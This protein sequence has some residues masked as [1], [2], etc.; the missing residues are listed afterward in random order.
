MR[1]KLVRDLV[2]LATFVAM[3][4]VAPAAFASTSSLASAVDAS[5]D[6]MS[7]A[8]SFASPA[9]PLASEAPAPSRDAA[10]ASQS[11][12]SPPPP[13]ANVRNAAPLCDA[14]GATMFAPPP[15]LQDTEQSLDSDC[16]TDDDAFGLGRD[17]H[18]VE[19]PRAPARANE[20]GSQEPPLGCAWPPIGRGEG[21]RVPAP[22]D[23]DV[24]RLPGHRTPLDR[25]PRA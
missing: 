16:P 20:A 15:Q 12:T 6:G 19:H 21:V 13:P 25:P 11:P 4:L 24:W 7:L 9:S 3:W 1:A 17:G 2:T 22:E 8:L 23:A 14:R 10:R 5:M 18:Q